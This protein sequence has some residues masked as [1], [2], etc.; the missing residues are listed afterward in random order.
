MIW[1][2]ALPPEVVGEGQG[3]ISLLPMLPHVRQVMGPV[4]LLPYHQDN[5]YSAAQMRHM[6]YSPTW[7]LQLVR[8]RTISCPPATMVSSSEPTAP[9]PSLAHCL[10]KGWYGCQ[11]SIV[12]EHQRGLR[13][14]RPG[15]S[16]WPFIVVSPSL[17]LK[18]AGTDLVTTEV[19]PPAVQLSDLTVFF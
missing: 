3:G 6:A 10:R 8:G 11:L 1:G 19:G 5:L 7:G 17:N 18:Q 9:E 4:C 12:L 2:P 13:Q 14:P 15:S 16:A